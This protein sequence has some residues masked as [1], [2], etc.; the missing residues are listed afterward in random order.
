MSSFKK[1]ITQVFEG[2][3]KSFQD[4][5][6]AMGSAV[7][8]AIVT[9]IRIQMDWPQQEAYNFLFN[10]L[11]LSFALGAILGLGAVAYEK[12]KYD[13][14][15]KFILANLVVAVAVGVAFLLLYNFGGTKLEPPGRIIR[16]TNLAAARMGVAM[17]VS[18]LAFIVLAGRSSDESDFSR[19]L[20]M[21]HKAFFIASIY[22]GVIELGASGVAGAVQA[23]LYRDMSGKVYMYIATIAGF[24]AYAIFTGYFP[25]FSKK[26][27]DERREIAQRQPKFIIILFEYIIIPIVLALTAVLLLWAVKTV[28][29]KEEVY[30]ERL[31]SIATAYAFVGI[32]IHIITSKSESGLVKLYRKI[33]PF[34]ALVILGFEA[35][36]LWIQYMKWGMKATEYYFILTWIFAIATIVMLLA[37]KE[38]SHVSIV[39]LL[40][41]LSIVSVLPVLGYYTLPV[42]MQASRL[43]QILMQEGLLKDGILSPATK[44]IPKDTKIAIT[45]SVVYLTNM[46]NAKLPAWLD[47]K[48]GES[49]TFKEKFGFDQTWPEPEYMPG[50]SKGTYLSLPAGA[51]DI[52]G[53]QWAINM[54]GGMGTEPVGVKTERGTYELVWNT[55]NENQIPVIEV[56]LNGKTII[57]KD[58]NEYL[59]EILAKYPPGDRYN[60]DVPAQDLM[61]RFESA[62]ADVLVLL[63]SVSVNLDPQSDKM[64]YWVDLN[65]IYLKEKP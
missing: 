41:T 48:L 39:A 38:K 52:G 40:C 18:F 3:A 53:Y 25:D 14:S 22:G 46:Q 37:K 64:Y 49:F 11:H 34:A 19:S 36:A 5:P 62:E 50:E 58:L 12:C 54:K 61:V 65:S 28:V 17:G 21:T 30:F 45:D 60:L 44:E 20:F 33:Y 31:S 6:A 29:S 42:K 43:E 9:M 8:F 63:N 1:S 51:V 26:S 23:L 4:F 57:D 35:R 16:V 10:C 13:D 56:R 59:D 47:K 55:M 24:L 15:K 32:W 2:A 7:A 27:G